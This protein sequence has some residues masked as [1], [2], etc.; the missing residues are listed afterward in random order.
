LRS[1]KEF[2][3][4]MKGKFDEFFQYNAPYKRFEESDWETDLKAI[5]KRNNP[6]AEQLWESGMLIHLFA[7]VTHEFAKEH[8]KN[9]QRF[10]EETETDPDEII[11]EDIEIIETPKERKEATSEEKKGFVLSIVDLLKEQRNEET[12]NEFAR[13][14]YKQRLHAGGNKA[15]FDVLDCLLED[16][17]ERIDVVVPDIE[18]FESVDHNIVQKTI[19]TNIKNNSS[20]VKSLA[21]LV[22]E[23]D[24]PRIGVAV[25]FQACL[26]LECDGRVELGQ[27]YGDVSVRQ[28]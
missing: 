15:L 3:R 2:K 19:I 26:Q 12:I 13:N 27:L 23:T 22:K 10:K 1:Q 6:S 9:C 4:Q 11:V 7:W 16:Q 28:T 21:G 24:D 8:F 17:T 20:T 5:I 14:L 18:I 25:T